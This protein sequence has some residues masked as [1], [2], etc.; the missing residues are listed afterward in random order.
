MLFKASKDGTVSRVIHDFAEKGSTE[1][2][3]E[4]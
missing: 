1:L 4:S 2:T 3:P